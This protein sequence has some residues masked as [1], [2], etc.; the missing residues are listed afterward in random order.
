ML[1][2][3]ASEV[4]PALFFSLLIITV[5][6]LPIFTLEGQEGTVE[7]PFADRS[8]RPRM[9]AEWKALDP[10]LRAVSRDQPLPPARAPGGLSFRGPGEFAFDL[11]ALKG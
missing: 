5:S 6:F 4:G 9:R 11:A 1:I 7:L 2:E 3:A 8:G 10:E